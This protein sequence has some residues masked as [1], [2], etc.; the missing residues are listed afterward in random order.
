MNSFFVYKLSSICI[1]N[2]NPDIFTTMLDITINQLHITVVNLCLLGF[3]ISRLLS[4][5]SERIEKYKTYILYEQRLNQKGKTLSDISHRAAKLL[6]LYRS[7]LLNQIKLRNKFRYISLMH[8]FMD[9]QM[10]VE[11]YIYQFFELEKECKE[12]LI[13]SEQNIDKIEQLNE[14]PDEFSQL[15][16]EAYTDCQNF[17]STINPQNKSSTLLKE[18]VHRILSKLQKLN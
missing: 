1:A 12:I 5:E 18:N 6:N 4:R 14:V 11:E 16:Q 13:R 3:C 8:D 9:D 17:K 7:M 2:A 15:L 10:S